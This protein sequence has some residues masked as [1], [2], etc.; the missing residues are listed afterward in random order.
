MI[1]PNEKVSFYTH[2]AGAL[3]AAAGTAYLVYRSSGDAQVFVT[4]LIYGISVTLLFTASS[5]YHAF[6]RGENDTSIFRKLDHLAIFIMIAGSYTP[7][8]WTYLT[9]G[10]LVFILTAQWALVLFGIFF[11]F[12]Y[13]SAPRQISAGIYVLMGWLAVVPIHKFFMAMPIEIF[14]LFIAGGVSFTAGAIIYAFKR[15]DPCPGTFGFHE[16]FHLFILAGAALHYTAM[17]LMLPS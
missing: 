13:L 11:K 2:F 1:T 4:M 6:K 17:L 10:W 14:L 5:M 7:P 9:G 15:P 8:S 16:I 12:F 3:A